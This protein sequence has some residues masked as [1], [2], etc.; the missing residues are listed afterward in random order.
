MTTYWTHEGYEL[1]VGLEVHVEL[2]TRTKLFSHAPNKF[3]DDPN[4]NVT[5]VCTGMPGSLPVLNEQAV[6]LAITL[7]LALNSEIRPSTFH[8]KNYFYPDMPKDYQISQFDLPI[9]NGGQIELPDGFV[10][11]LERAHLEEDT[12]KTTH[13]GGS[14]RINDADYALVDYNRAGVPLLEIVSN[15]DIRHPDQARAYA[16]ELRQILVATSVSDARMEEGSMRVDANVSVRHIGADELRTRCEVKNLNSIRSLGRAIEYEARRQIDLYESGSAPIQETRHWDENSG[17]TSSMRSKEE[18]HD[19]RFFTEPDLVPIAPSDEWIDRLR[20]ALP[21]LPA[22]RRENLAAVIGKDASAAA[23]AVSRGLDKLVLTAIEAG[24][25][26][27]RVMV[28]VNNNMSD[29][30]AIDL[31]SG[32][33]IDFVKMEL[34]GE[35]TSTQA[36]LVIAEMIETG[37]SAADIAKAKGFESLG[38]DVLVGAVDAAITENPDDWARF[39]DGE[40]KL[41]GFFVGKVMKATRGQADGKAV[42]ALLRERRG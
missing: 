21:V 4:T 10:V 30:R 36:K 31:D 5:P 38:D 34:A 32:L 22:Q 27:D 6:E 20:K 2:E 11:G 14:G 18:A 12:G 1:V 7:G 33:F 35:I 29:D 37:S 23:F 3:G 26:A 13:M 17:R 24:A 8:R 40:E 28:H 15:P 25:D 19:Y 42:T 41:A 9:C 16:E 39:C